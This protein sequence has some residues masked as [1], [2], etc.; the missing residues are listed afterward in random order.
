M[1]DNKIDET[2]LGDMAAIHEEMKI[3]TVYLKSISRLVIAITFVASAVLLLLIVTILLVFV[4]LF[5]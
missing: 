3:H 5:V 1:A 2:P 4:G